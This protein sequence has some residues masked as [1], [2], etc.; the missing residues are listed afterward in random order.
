MS[1]IRLLVRCI[2]GNW[3]GIVPGGLASRVVAALS[4]DPATFEELQQA[5]KRFIHFPAGAIPLAELLP[6]DWDTPHD[7]GLVVI[8]LVGRMVAADA[9]TVRLARKG[10]LFWQAVGPEGEVETT[11]VNLPFELAADWRLSD[12]VEGWRGLAEERRESPG[13]ARID[14]RSVLYGQ[15]LY[16]YIALRVWDEYREAESSGLVE[17]LLR[18]QKS[19]SRINGRSDQ[20][21]H[22]AVSGSRPW[23]QGEFE[24]AADLDDGDPPLERFD[25]RGSNAEWEIIKRLHVDWL[26]T[27]RSDL[28]ERSPRQWALS[29]HE[30][31]MNDLEDQTRR[32]SLLDV[33]PPGVAPDS[34]AF[35]FSPFG[36]HEW[37]EYYELVREL[38]WDSWFRLLATCSESTLPDRARR[39]SFGV[40]EQRSAWRQAEA[41]RLAARAEEWLDEPKF[42][43]PGRT[44][45]SV[46]ER[47]RCRLP[48]R[49][50][51]DQM[52]LEPDCPICEMLARSHQPTFWSQDGCNFDDDYAFDQYS[53]TAEE[54]REK[55]VDWQ[56]F[57]EHSSEQE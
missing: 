38:L 31:I 23:L 7:L 32:W 24:L 42:D 49:V 54:W 50:P 43:L 35:R 25:F 14:F 44:P 19:P 28:A 17:H 8:D 16:D 13:H 15:P 36:T 9:E 4:A 30:H 46:I 27:P 45:R 33:E 41:A 55:Q 20:S 48:E 3:S 10:G 26:L 21:F 53:E 51:A 57:A 47:E 5:L 18:G 34:V 29:D 12:Q 39:A 52:S 2:D 11:E 22:Q 56:G 37:V 40:A 1:T 6:G